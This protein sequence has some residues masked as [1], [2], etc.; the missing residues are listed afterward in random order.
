MYKIKEI[1]ENI[2]KWYHG[3]TE[4]INSWS[5]KFTGAGDDQ[6]GIG[7]YFS[8]N[9]ED[10]SGYAR[11][12]DSGHVYTVEL[13]TDKFLKLVKKPD[14]QQLF[15]LVQWSDNWKEKLENIMGNDSTEM[16]WKEFKSLLK[17][18]ASM[19]EACKEIQRHF[20]YDDPS[21]YCSSM[22]ALGYDGIIIKKSFMNTY[23]AVVWNPKIIRNI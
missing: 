19:F 3:S 8:S 13:K 21:E 14:I 6:E 22:V 4:K 15:S 18:E 12:S 2:L 11:K 20:Y 9:Y 17:Q 7:I 5:T 1:K 23:H 10:A 16:N